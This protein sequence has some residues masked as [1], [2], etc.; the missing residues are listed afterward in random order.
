MAHGLGHVSVS[1]IVPPNVWK[2]RFRSQILKTNVN[3]AALSPSE[4]LQAA[5]SDY[6]AQ[7]RDDDGNTWWMSA[8]NLIRNHGKFIFNGT[9]QCSP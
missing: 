6:E 1:A 8:N 4:R 9:P 3:N 5:G 7:I 2:A